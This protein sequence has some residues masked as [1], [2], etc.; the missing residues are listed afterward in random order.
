VVVAA[1]NRSHS[2]DSSG[3][4][5][6]RLL[7]SRAAHSLISPAGLSISNGSL[8]LPTVVSP[9]H[10]FFAGYCIYGWG[11]SKHWRCTRSRTVVISTKGR[12]LSASEKSAYF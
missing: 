2:I 3:G 8:L 9:L 1:I 4:F 12:N 10:V 5:S 11:A 6:L 7:H